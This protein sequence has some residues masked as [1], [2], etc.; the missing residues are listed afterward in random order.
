[1]TDRKNPEHLKPYQ[2]KPGQSGNPGGFPKG[3]KK[4]PKMLRNELLRRLAEDSGHSVRALVD[5]LLTVA[6]DDEHKDW[7]T[8]WKMVHDMADGPI[9]KV[10][11]AETRGNASV[12]LLRENLGEGGDG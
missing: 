1:M 12:T 3:G 6:K 5:A 2:F 9:A 11:E 10:V 8:A 7:I 4:V